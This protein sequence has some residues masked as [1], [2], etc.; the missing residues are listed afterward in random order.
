M[1]RSFLLSML[2]IH[3]S[4]Q[5]AKDSLVDPR[6]AEG[7]RETLTLLQVREG[8]GKLHGFGWKPATKFINALLH[9]T[10]DNTPFRPQSR[11]LAEQFSAKRTL[12]CSWTYGAGACKR[13][14]SWNVQKVWTMLNLETILT[15]ASVSLTFSS[16]CSPKRHSNVHDLCVST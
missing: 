3:G 16:W 12:T 4:V 8:L 7:G 14:S 9:S 11:A 5:S 1:L 6:A 15:P 10:T 2:C 13:F